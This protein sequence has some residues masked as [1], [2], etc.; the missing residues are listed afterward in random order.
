VNIR[1]PADLA[2]LL[3]A[4]SIAG[5]LLPEA[6]AYSGLA[7]LPPQAG[8]IGLF[9]G[10][11]CYGLIGRSRCAIVSATSS[12]AAVLAAATSALGA[13]DASARVL[14]AGIL[15]P[16]TGVAFMLAG[17]ARLGAISN[18]IARPV[19]RGFAFGLALVI[20]VK[21]IPG[22]AGLHTH[23]GSFL[24]LVLELVQTLSAGNPAALIAGL[25]ALAGLFGL[26]RLRRVPGALVVIVA[27]IAA[28]GWLA[29]HGVALT[30][31]IHL[32]LT[33]PSFLRP[34]HRRHPPGIGPTEIAGAGAP[35]LA[36]AHRV[37]PGADVHSVCGV[38]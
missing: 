18:L 17:G 33:P 19:L 26:E 10:L 3:A 4:L 35:Q 23:S 28:S 20:A 12:S 24:P 36:T 21:Q 5:L 8:V 13:G 15:V 6:V 22:L 25:A 9:A 37:L 32:Q 2:D 11:I 31:A 38:L 27:G 34:N 29:V 30:G 7:N 16:C 14:L 1:R